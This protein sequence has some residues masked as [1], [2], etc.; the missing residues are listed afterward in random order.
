[1]A[2]EQVDIKQGL[3]YIR[4]SLIFMLANTISQ[5]YLALM[6]LVVL[7]SNNT[8]HTGVGWFH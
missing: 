1:M 8:K 5:K 3:S 2:A 4:T 6:Y 7:S